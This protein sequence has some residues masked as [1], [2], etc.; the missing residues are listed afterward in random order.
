MNWHHWNISRTSVGIKWVSWCF[1]L[2]IFFINIVY[3]TN[4]YVE[5]CTY[6][7]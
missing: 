4:N 3:E 2:N 1:F 5:I 6:C 7:S